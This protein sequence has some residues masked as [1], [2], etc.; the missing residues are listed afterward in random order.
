MPDI[1]ALTDSVQ[2][3]L[4]AFRVPIGIL[5]MNYNLIKDSALINNL[6]V[7][8]DSV[9]HDG[10]NTSESPYTSHRCFAAAALIDDCPL[11]SV[12]FL[13][14]DDY[15]FEN[16]GEEVMNYIIDFNDG[17]GPQILDPNDDYT[18]EYYTTGVKYLEIEAWM[19]G[20]TV[21]RCTATFTVSEVN[22]I[23]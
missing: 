9:L 2:A 17:Q 21:L 12:T 6:L 1:L 13:L 3:E 7:I 19:I 18:V 5:N 10:P 23:M 15:L 8:Q 20:G 16:T 4:N 11:A 14:R 22:P